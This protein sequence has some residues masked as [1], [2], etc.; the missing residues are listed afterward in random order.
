MKSGQRV[1]WITRFLSLACVLTFIAVAQPARA[2][3]S[4]ATDDPF[5]IQSGCTVP[6]CGDIY[7]D[8]NITYRISRKDCDSCSW[9]YGYIYPGQHKGGY[10]NDGIDWDRFAVP[11]NCTVSYTVDGSRYGWWNGTSSYLWISWH[12][13]QTVRLKS[14]SC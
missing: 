2:S 13:D 4:H 11:P 7:N 14:H 8:D 3:D 6:P 5:T 12:S 1:R 10:W 9:I